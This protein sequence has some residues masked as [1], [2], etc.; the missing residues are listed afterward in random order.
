MRLQQLLTSTTELNLQSSVSSI[1]SNYGAGL[2]W[3]WATKKTTTWTAGINSSYTNDYTTNRHFWVNGLNLS[4]VW[5]APRAETH[6]T[7]YSD[8]N[9]AA[10]DLTTWS[11]KPAVRMPDVLTIADE[12]ITTIDGTTSSDDLNTRHFL[13]ETAV[14]P[15]A[16]EIQYNPNTGT[17]SSGNWVESYPGTPINSNVEPIFES[18][19]IMSSGAGMIECEYKVGMQKAILL[20]NSDYAHVE[21]SGNNW[22]NGQDPYWPSSAGT[23]AETC[24]AGNNT[25]CVFATVDSS[26]SPDTPS[27]KSA[28][29]KSTSKTLSVSKL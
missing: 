8:P 21:G 10:Q 6:V 1:F 13:S 12:R 24:G 11:A 23:P 27:A 15:A 9:I 25:G 7:G 18:A 16:N 5:G 28:N 29:N 20:T 26:A 2:N 14:C 22:H 17:Y 19:N 4:I 3:I